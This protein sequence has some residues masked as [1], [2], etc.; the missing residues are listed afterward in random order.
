MNWLIPENEL[1]REQREFLKNLIVRSDN[2]HILGFPGSGKT[3][4]LLYAA[5]KLK[6]QNHD[7]KILF[8]EF[9][10]ALIKMIEAAILQLPYHDINVVTYYDFFNNYYGETFDYILCDEVQDVPPKVIEKMKKIAKRVIIAG[11]PNQS[12]YEDDPQWGLPPCTQEQLATILSPSSLPLTVIHRLSKFIINAVDKF[13]PNMKITSGRVSMMKTHPMI[14]LWK[15]SNQRQEVRSIMKDAQNYLQNDESIGVLLPTHNKIQKFANLVLSTNGKPEWELTKDRYG[16]VEYS[17][18][19]EHFEKNGIPMQY[20]ANGFGNF[21]EEKNKITLITYHSSKGL[22]FDRV[23]MPFCN[24]FS[25]YTHYEESD[26]V[27]FMVALTRSRGDMV[28]SYTAELNRLVLSFKDECTYKNLD[29]D[30]VP[31]IFGP[32]PNQTVKKNS[33]DNND[34]FGW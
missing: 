13:M 3:I 2:E 24:H 6:D 19:N 11:D 29:D 20:V 22:D 10:H 4:L 15:G 12:I 32:K 14:R 31:N 30:D 7:A 18:L 9:T 33:D 1:D 25:P 28:I 17:K 26:K 23:Y 27:L 16:N 5:K 34:I 21:T 8:V